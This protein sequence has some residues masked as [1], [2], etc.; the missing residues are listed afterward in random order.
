[1]CLA[2]SILI[3]ATISFFY[4]SAAGLMPEVDFGS[5]FLGLAILLVA[6]ISGRLGAS[7]AC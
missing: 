6:V 2:A 5:C 1:M 7:V 3:L 4:F